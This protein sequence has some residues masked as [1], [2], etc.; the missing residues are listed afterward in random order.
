MSQQIERL[1]GFGR[2]VVFAILGIHL[3]IGNPRESLADAELSLSPTHAERVVHDET[4]GLNAALMV[5]PGYVGA[6]S[7]TPVAIFG[8]AMGY[9]L[10][11]QLELGAEYELTGGVSTVGG[12]VNYF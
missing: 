8:V 4:N 12:D 1:K 11:S 9:K 3:I 6:L 7:S 2:P 10:P 5:G